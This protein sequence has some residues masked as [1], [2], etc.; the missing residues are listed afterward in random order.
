MRNKDHT[1]IIGEAKL[2][3]DV[4]QF[5]FELKLCIKENDTMLNFYTCAGNPATPAYAIP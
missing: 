5:Q 4:I 1:V 2:N 3:F